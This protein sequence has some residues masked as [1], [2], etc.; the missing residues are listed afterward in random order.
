MPVSGNTSSGATRRSGIVLSSKSPIYQNNNN[1]SAETYRSG[2]DLISKTSS[3]LG[4]S[5]SRQYP[6]S[7]RS[8]ISNPIFLSS[9]AGEEET[10]E[11]FS[12]RSSRS[13]SQSSSQSFHRSSPRSSPP[14][15]S[16][17]RSPRLVIPKSPSSR[18]LSPRSPS[19]KSL[20]P[21]SLPRTPRSSI[22]NPI[23]PISSAGEEE[24]KENF[25]PRS[26]L[27][28]SRSFHRSSPR[29][30]PFSKSLSPLSLPKSPP[31]P[32]SP[33]LQKSPVKPKPKPKPKPRAINNKNISP[34]AKKSVSECQALPMCKYVSTEMRKYCR[35][36]NNTRKV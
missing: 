16:R 36:K 29:R 17:S 20:S 21:L 25:S 15:R 32:P 11:N 4:R 2:V 8:S 28:S 31:R 34:C 14:R 23:F 35:K 1:S 33:V 9:S 26:F 10:K 22:S 3:N 7:P 12:P 13:S 27:S 19:R 6:S 24:T 30:S 18:S 5:I